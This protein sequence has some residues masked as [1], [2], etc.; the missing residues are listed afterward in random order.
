MANLT[1]P[2]LAEIRVNSLP[3]ASVENL[4]TLRT[5]MCGTTEFS[6]QPQQTFLRRVLSPDSPTRDLLMVHGTGVGKTCAENA[7][8][9]AVK[10]LI[11]VINCIVYGIG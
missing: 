1:H 10:R 5:E 7:G 4:Q 9:I 8:P 3:P 11:H 6:L 2:E